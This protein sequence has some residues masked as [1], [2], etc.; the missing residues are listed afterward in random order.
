M[1]IFENKV[2]FTKSKLGLRPFG[3]MWESRVDEVPETLSADKEI[4]SNHG[5]SDVRKSE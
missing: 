2:T 4:E 5:T 1:N 3:K